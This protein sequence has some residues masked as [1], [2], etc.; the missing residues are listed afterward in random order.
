MSKVDWITWKTNPNELINPNTVLI[1]IEELSSDFYQYLNHSIY[2]V[3]EREISTGGLNKS[4]F[5][6]VGTSPANEIAERILEKMNQISQI[7]N[8]LYTNLLESCKEQRKEEK[9][10]LTKSI[11]DKILEEEKILDNTLKLQEK[12]RNNPMMQQELQLDNIIELTKERIN[13]LKKLLEDANSV[14]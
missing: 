4:S 13:K 2:E 10:Q 7:L 12:I 6:I 5:N 14:E 1:K 11:E 8:K 3:L 9:K